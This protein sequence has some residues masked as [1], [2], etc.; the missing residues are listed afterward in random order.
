VKGIPTLTEIATSW[1]SKDNWVWEFLK[2]TT[3][4]QRLNELFWRAGQDKT[5][6]SYVIE[7]AI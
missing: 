6:N 1:D 7:V 4:Y 2:T 5:A 3:Q